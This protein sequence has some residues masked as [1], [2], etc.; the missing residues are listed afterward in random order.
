MEWQLPEILN[1]EDIEN[2]NKNLAL[3]EKE[4]LHITVKEDHTFTFAALPRFNS[5]LW[6]CKHINIEIYTSISAT[7]HALHQQRSEFEKY[8]QPYFLLLLH[9]SNKV[10]DKEGN[11]IKKS[12]LFEQEEYLLKIDGT[13]YSK[14]SAAAFFFDKYNIQIYSS[15][16]G[17]TQSKNIDMWE[18]YRRVSAVIRKTTNDRLTPDYLEPIILNLLFEGTQNIIDHGLSD[19]SGVPIQ[20]IQ[21]IDFKLDLWAKDKPYEKVFGNSLNEYYKKYLNSI[22]TKLSGNDPR[23]MQINITD[24]G[25]GIAE[26]YT[27]NE[28][29]YTREKI[30][31]E[32]NA[33]W[34]ATNPGK[35]R[36]HPSITGK[37]MGLYKIL[38]T[39]ARLKGLII[40][41]SGRLELAIH[42]LENEKGA[43]D[44]PLSSWFCIERAFLPGT[45]ISVIFP[46]NSS[47]ALNQTKLDL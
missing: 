22:T 26:T 10:F 15:I 47:L 31:V 7:K 20:Q 32:K 24:S 43:I 46:W 35:S 23:L 39:V 1:A 30:E 4:I 40:F 9:Y 38:N 19:L 36:K 25:I 8:T 29:I 18:F 11:D 5:L 42:F 27:S 33:L 3:K 37:G 21:L 41:R 6:K 2:F 12:L 28:H 13:I 34:E 16:F 44:Y 14:N 45:T 17:Y